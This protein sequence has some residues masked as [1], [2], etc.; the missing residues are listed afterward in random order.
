MYRLIKIALKLFPRPLLIKISLVIHKAIAFFMKGNNVHCP[1]CNGSY[2]KFLPY[3]YVNKRENALCPGCLSLERHRALWLYLSDNTAF[4]NRKAK[5]LHI[6]P[7]QCFVK[8]FRK[9][10]NFTYTTG[11]LESPLADVKMD[12]CNMPF[13]DSSFDIIICNH[14]LEHIVD[15]IK[16]MK[17]IYRV[18]S[19]D[20][21]AILQVPI[22][23][24]EQNTD[25]DS[26]VTDKNEREKR[27]G[28]YDHVRYYGMDYFDRLISTGF[29]IDKKAK[30]YI[31][32]LKSEELNL[33]GIIKDDILPI[34]TK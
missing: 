14:V 4:F 1:I 2:R 25:E 23:I 31:D 34:M 33:F 17:E 12:V 20:G 13:K 30:Q 16:A 29:H 5:M 11:D 27:F 9:N 8:R 21:M 10:T 6:A 22:K 7:E 15:D 18:L 32:N 28:Q 24:H 26:S 3:G 19:A